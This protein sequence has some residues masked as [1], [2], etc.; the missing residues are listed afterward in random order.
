MNCPRAVAITWSSWL[1][2]SFANPESLWENLALAVE[3]WLGAS[4]GRYRDIVALPGSNAK[5]RRSARV[6]SVALARLSPPVSSHD[7][8]GRSSASAGT[9]SSASNGDGAPNCSATTEASVAQYLNIREILHALSDALADHLERDAPS[10][11][12]YDQE[13]SPLPP[14]THWTRAWLQGSA[15]G[16]GQTQRSARVYRTPQ[17]QCRTAKLPRSSNYSDP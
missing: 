10:A 5:R 13:S 11:E 3:S 14:H 16:L 1:A 7:R 6:A 4:T 17:A 8:L 2:H 15:S 9:C 12:Y